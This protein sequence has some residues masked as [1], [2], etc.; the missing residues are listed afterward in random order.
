[1]GSDGVGDHAC[2]FRKL[3]VD[4]DG[5]LGSVTVD[6][7]LAGEKRGEEDLEGSMDGRRVRIRAESLKQ[8][9]NMRILHAYKVFCHRDHL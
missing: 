7:L 3:E 9:G 2:V 6:E 4:A 1:M 5:L 8:I